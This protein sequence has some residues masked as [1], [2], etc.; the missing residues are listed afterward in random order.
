M[1]CATLDQ[2]IGVFFPNPP[3]PF[4]LPDAPAEP[5]QGVIYRGSAG[6]GNDSTVQ[7]MLPAGFS[8]VDAFSD[9]FR[10]VWISEERRAI[11]TYCEGDLDLTIDRNASLFYARMSSATRFYIGLRGDSSPKWTPETARMQSGGTFGS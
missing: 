11:L 4:G 9:T 10:T 7:R 8:V 3:H 1:P 5:G 2:F 6:F